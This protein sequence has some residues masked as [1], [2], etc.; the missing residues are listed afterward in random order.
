[1]H[2]VWHL[3]WFSIEELNSTEYWWIPER[4]GRENIC[5]PQTRVQASIQSLYFPQTCSADQFSLAGSNSITCLWA[6]FNARE[7]CAHS[8]SCNA[9]D[10]VWPAE[11]LNSR[12]H[13]VV[14]ELSVFLVFFPRN[15]LLGL[16]WHELSLRGLWEC[17]RTPQLRCS[18]QPSRSLQGCHRSFPLGSHIICT[19]LH[20][21][22]P[23]MS[24]SHV[25]SECYW[26]RNTSAQPLYTAATCESL[27]QIR[28][29]ILIYSIVI[30]FLG[31]SHSLQGL[32]GI[33]SSIAGIFRDWREKY[34]QS[35]SLLS[36]SFSLLF[37]S[38]F[39]S[40]FF[41]FPQL[42]SGYQCCPGWSSWKIMAHWSRI[43]KWC[44]PTSIEIPLPV[45]RG[46]CFRMLRYSFGRTSWSEI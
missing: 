8:Q 14:L 42:F 19:T 22:V 3:G 2:A 29:K 9:R 36:L 4:K 16:F 12:M 44:A 32:F 23:F 37:F 30:G 1:M 25:S 10:C 17:L 13:F 39:L 11:H 5:I 21:F 6:P 40:F 26:C 34:L 38:F 45:C 20:R 43:C 41:F 31:N 35:E 15:E 33:F 7:R 46:C 24:H 28:F 18:W 27:C